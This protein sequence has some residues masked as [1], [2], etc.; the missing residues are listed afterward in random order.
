VQAL[1][2]T[3][4]ERGHD[5]AICTARIGGLPS[6]SP[7]GGVTVRRIGRFPEFKRAV[8]I[9]SG[10]APSRPSRDTLADFA[11][12]LSELRPDVVH[13]HNPWLLGPGLIRA[14]VQP[15]VRVGVTL[16]DYWPVCVRRSMIRVDWQPCS[17][18]DP[19][20]CRLC[21]LRAPSTL[22][23]LDL[24]GI[25]REMAG[26]AETL[27][28]CQ[29]VTA[30]SQFV[31]ERVSRGTGRRVEVVPNGVALALPQ[32]AACTAQDTGAYVLFASR[33]TTVKGYGL[34]LEAFGRPELRDYVLA[35]A[36]D[37]ARPGGTPPNVRVLGQQLPD[38]MG[39]IVAGASCVIVPS[40]WPENCPM[41]ILEALSAGVPVVASRIGGIPELVED[42]VTG[43]L[44]AP[45]D[46]TALASAVV[47]ACTDD[48]LRA[49]ARRS[50]PS[51]VA[52]RFSMAAM[53]A[54]LEG[55]YAA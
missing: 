54:R 34:A 37:P 2:H 24:L 48:A 20:N 15:G 23:S 12:A 19:F 9:A 21:R 42:G 3:L 30:P 55:L 38:R 35:V 11:V 39:P 41:I 47:R 49:S 14:A 36:G 27:G 29:F 22:R 31:A 52:E 10:T 46:S 45:S 4:A 13:F 43:L 8:A 33:P 17:G 50:G 32:P 16:H 5:V 18:P 28:A 40:S 25:E 44:V 51:A 6:Q 7:D 26:H 53:T 1:A